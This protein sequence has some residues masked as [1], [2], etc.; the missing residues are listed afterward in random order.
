MARHTA[1]RRN[2]RWNCT[3]RDEYFRCTVRVDRGSILK[4]L[5]RVQL[6]HPI[7]GRYKGNDDELP[8][9]YFTWE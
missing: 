9:A 1:Y 2:L 3:S 6:S 8:H 7:L 4:R 5:G